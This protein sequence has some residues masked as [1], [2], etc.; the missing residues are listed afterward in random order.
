MTRK[1]VLSFDFDF[2]IREDFMWDFGHSETVNLF[3]QAAWLARYTSIDLYKGTRIEKYADFLPEDTL[4][5]LFKAGF[6]LGKN[7]TYGVADSHRHAYNF[8]KEFKEPVDVY[9]FDAH[10]D[11]YSANQNVID[12]GNWLY[13]L[14][15]ENAVNKVT[16]I[17]PKWEEEPVG[18]V[19]TKLF[20][21]VKG[22]TGYDISDRIK[23][24]SWEDFKK[25][26]T[27]L[28]EVPLNGIFLCRSGVWV[29]PHHDARFMALVKQ[30]GMFTKSKW[31]DYADVT[32]RTYPTEAEAIKQRVGLS[33]QMKQL[34][35]GGE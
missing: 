5:E 10:S 33:K 19:L 12:C 17:Y 9:H 15:Q 16:W 4:M 31:I 21:L 28:A 32:K 22:D 26:D 30:L 18:S 13:K 23:A 35:E 20:E 7:Y 1:S 11:M 6:A 24:C 2:F 27:P 8:I 14:I 3:Q 25:R 29:P 34:E